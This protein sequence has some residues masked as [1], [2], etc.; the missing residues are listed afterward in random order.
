V[1]WGYEDSHGGGFR[2]GF[3]ALVTWQKKVS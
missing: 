2:R 1:G 3:P